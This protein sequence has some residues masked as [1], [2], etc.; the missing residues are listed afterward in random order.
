MPKSS[1][2]PDYDQLD[3]TRPLLWFLNLFQK[4]RSAI[5]RLYNWVIG[6]SEKKQAEQALAGLSFAESSFFPIPPDPLLIAMVTARPHKWRRLAFIA[7]TA[8]VIGGMFG[9]FIG[10]ALQ[11]TV[12][13]WLI[14]VYH[15]QEQFLRVGELYDKYTVLAVIVAGFTPIPYKLFSIAAGVFAV[16]LPL[17]AAASFVGR[18]G[19]FFL[20]G[21]LMHHFGKRYKD[22]IEKYID[23]LGVLFILLLVLGIVAVKYVL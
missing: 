18:G 2:A 14:N 9:Y 19:R 23:T 3:D 22:K 17:F 15:L 10:T 8:S 6:W 13:N 11:E 12:G 1:N 16:N 20:V 5:R 21:F 4:P 7:T